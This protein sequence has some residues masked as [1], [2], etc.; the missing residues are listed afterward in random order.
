MSLI[1]FDTSVLVN[2]LRT[3][4]Y[5]ARIQNVRGLVRLSSVVL[6]ELWRGGPAAPARENF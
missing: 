6:A 5:E 2:D 3:G 4:K 1:V